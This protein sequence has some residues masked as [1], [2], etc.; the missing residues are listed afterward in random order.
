MPHNEEVHGYWIANEPLPP[1]FPEGHTR[2]SRKQAPNADN[3]YGS[4]FKFYRG[5]N[6]RYW[7][8]SGGTVIVWIPT[9]REL[10]LRKLAERAR[11][12]SDLYDRR[13]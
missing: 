11:A 1:N 5:E 6:G 13:N 9:E 7:G 4:D 8:V 12:H 2:V 10:S 3:I